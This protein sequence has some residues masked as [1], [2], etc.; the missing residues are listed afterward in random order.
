MDEEHKQY[1]IQKLTEDLPALRKFLGV[2]QAELAEIIG[3]SK[4][5]ISN[6]ENGR[7]KMTWNVFVALMAVLTSNSKTNSIIEKMEIYDSEIHDY[8]SGNISEAKHGRK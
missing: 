5:T 4:S 3:M 7:Q 8:L 6:I 2:S 1:H